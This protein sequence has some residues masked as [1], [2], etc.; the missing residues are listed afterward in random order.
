MEE[1]ALGDGTYDSGKLRT[2]A[3]SDEPGS[4]S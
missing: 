4:Q 1:H 3:V 2:H